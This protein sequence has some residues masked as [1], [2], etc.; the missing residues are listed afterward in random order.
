MGVILE[1]EPDHFFAINGD[2][3]AEELPCF[4]EGAYTP[5]AIL[6]SI[7]ARREDVSFKQGTL[8]HEV[9][10]FLATAHNLGAMITIKP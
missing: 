5:L 7:L 9:L 10:L 8:A 1:I 6:G 4:K 3:W 2:D